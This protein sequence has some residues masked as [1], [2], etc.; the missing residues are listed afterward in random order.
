MVCDGEVEQDV[1]PLRVVR[2]AGSDEQRWARFVEDHPEGLVYHHPGW[3]RV[4]TEEYR[5]EPVCLACEDARGRLRAVLPLLPTHGLPLAQGTRLGRRLSSLPRTPVAGPLAVDAAAA[6]AV[7]R[8]AVDLARSG[9]Y[10]S[11]E[12]KLGTSPIGCAGAG[13]QDLTWRPAY[14][15]E[16][17]ADPTK[18]CLGSGRNQARLRWSVGKA[19]RLGVRVRAAETFQ[20]LRRWY[21]LYL[22]TMRWHVVPPRP[23]R[24]FVAMWSVLRPNGLMRLLLAE[25]AEG[26]RSRLLAGS[27]HLM[28]GQVVF[29]AFSG[30]SRAEHSYRPNDAIQWHAIEDACRSGYRWY[31]FGEVPDRSFGLAE[32][33]RK[34]GAREWPLYRSYYPSPPARRLGCDSGRA[35]GT[36]TSLSRRIWRRLPLAATA[37]VGQRLYSYL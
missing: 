3:V 31:D 35:P 20:D 29:Y 16:L 26:G 27:V 2:L 6:A 19:A 22:E 23:F 14:R 30:A 33:K 13:V 11:M 1:S 28:C 18:L 21:A 34:W 17:H 7:T 9:P 5:N 4:L 36:G 24:L 12:L 8:A 32:F 25:R 37:V 15:L 10:P